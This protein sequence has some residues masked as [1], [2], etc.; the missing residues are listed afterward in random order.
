MKKHIF[1]LLVYLFISFS[2][3]G[4]SS[5][6]SF[7]IQPMPIDAPWPT[8]ESLSFLDTE[9]QNFNFFCASEFHRTEMALKQKKGFI[10]Y[11]SAKKGLDKLVIEFPYAYGYWINRYLESGDTTLLRTITD[12][13][14]TFDKSSRSKEITHNSYRFF[15]WLYAFNQSDKNNIKVVGVDLNESEKAAIELWSIQQF[16]LKDSLFISF[17]ESYDMLEG[18]VSSEKVKFSVIKKWM[19][20]FNAEFKSNKKSV[21]EVMGA[22][23]K[24]FEKIRLGIEDA[25]EYHNRRA[26]Q[27]AS[28]TYREQVLIRNFKREITPT[29][30]I[31]A[32]FGAGHIFLG[33][34]FFSLRDKHDFMMTAINKDPKYAN[35]TLSMEVHFEC[36]IKNDDK[37]CRPSV[38]AGEYTWW[39]EGIAGLGLKKENEATHDKLISSLNRRNVAIDL[40]NA[41]EGLYPLSKLYQY[42]III[43]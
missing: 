40:R 18:M 5:V 24:E 30:I 42:L 7:G 10:T 6:E 12:K 36:D 26:S 41:K 3:Q 21:Q 8:P 25:V 4:Q 23:Y 27:R 19:S 15:R 16:L 2:T 29:D 28:R 22:E 1:L 11:L 43:F 13:H 20:L 37:P 14:P 31:Y 33:D 9:L 32:Q 39:H 35:R 17:G 34:S 38:L